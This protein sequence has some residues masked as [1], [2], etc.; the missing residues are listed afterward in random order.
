ESINSNCWKSSG[1]IPMS[2]DSLVVEEVTAGM[3]KPPVLV[4]MLELE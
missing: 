4:G 1:E 3:L 2:A